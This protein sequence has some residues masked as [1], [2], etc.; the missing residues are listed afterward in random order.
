M[1]GG[2]HAERRAEDSTVANAG[3]DLQRARQGAAAID[4]TSMMTPDIPRA[5]TRGSEIETRSYRGASDPNFDAS[6]CAVKPRTRRRCKGSGRVNSERTPSGFSATLP[7]IVQAI[8]STDRARSTSRTERP[9]ADRKSAH[10]ALHGQQCA[11][12]DPL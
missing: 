4:C 1:S 5:T 2:T 6:P 10:A 11:A 9:L 3:Q 7:P 12:T 8:W